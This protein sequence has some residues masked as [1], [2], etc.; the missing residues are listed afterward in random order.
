MHTI[1][2]HVHSIIHVFLAKPCQAVGTVFQ[3]SDAF[4]VFFTFANSITI[5]ISIKRFFLVLFGR[6][7]SSA[8][9]SYAAA[10][11][12]AS[13]V[14]IAIRSTTVTVGATLS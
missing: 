4:T 14:I 3:S 10:I 7:R 13:G 1:L 2:I 11:T 6:A 5:F 9:S 8:T 12:S